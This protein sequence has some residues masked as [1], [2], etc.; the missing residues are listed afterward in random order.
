MTTELW[1]MKPCQK[2]CNLANANFCD[3]ED[4]VRLDPDKTVEGLTV[5]SDHMLNSQGG[6]YRDATVADIIDALEEK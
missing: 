2:G 4:W 3:H 5:W 1:L 6:H